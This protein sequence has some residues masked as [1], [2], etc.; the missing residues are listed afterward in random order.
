MPSGVGAAP[1]VTSMLKLCLNEGLMNGHSRPASQASLRIS[2][3]L[4]FISHPD[5]KLPLQTWTNISPT[6]SLSSFLLL[7]AV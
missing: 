4:S 2:A 5:G 7:R 6:F 3:S 1:A